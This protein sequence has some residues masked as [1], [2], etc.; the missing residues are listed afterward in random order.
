MDVL[1]PFSPE[2]PKT[3]LSGTFNS[4]ERETFAR[5]M[6]ADTLAT[7]RETGHTPR[8][9]ATESIDC[10]APVS[11]DDRALTPAVNSVIAGVSPI[12]VIVAD[13]ALMTESAVDRLFTPEADIVVAPGRGGGTNALVVRHPEFRV[14]YHGASYLDHRQIA[15]EIEAN[16]AV[17]D[18]H[19]LTTDIDER[20]DLAELLIHGSGTAHDW[21][22]DRGFQLSVTEGRVGIQRS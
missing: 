15:R 20:E 11:V 8:V 18:S 5:K 22:V 1:V 4:A 7:L 17:V 19:R 9:L 16:V 3:R 12:A 21:L 6:L 2:R 10:S 14:D 13:L